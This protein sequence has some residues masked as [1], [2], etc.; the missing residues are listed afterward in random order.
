M[1]LS[2]GGSLGGGLIRAIAVAVSVTLG[3]LWPSVTDSAPAPKE[4]PSTTTTIVTTTTAPGV[5]PS[6]IAAWG[7]VAVCESGGWVVLG[8]AYPNS[9]GMTAANWYNFGGTSDVSP[10]AQVKVAERF[11]AA[12]GIGIPDQNGC[13]GAW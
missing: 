1:P 9:L 10:E 7:K 11:R 12:Y 2:S 5:D 3:V 8:S 13:E 6:L 4:P